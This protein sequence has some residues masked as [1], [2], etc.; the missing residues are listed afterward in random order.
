M[1][2]HIAIITDA[3][4]RFEIE[5]AANELEEGNQI[6][7]PDSDARTEFLDDCISCILDKF[8]LYEHYCPDYAMEILDVAKLYGYML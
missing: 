2:K 7:F 6:H 1:K 4:I 3:D 8:D 5:T